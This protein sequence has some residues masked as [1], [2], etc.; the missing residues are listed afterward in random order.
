MRQKCICGLVGLILLAI[1]LHSRCGLALADESTACT[2][3]L[4]QTPTRDSPPLCKG[5]LGGYQPHDSTFARWPGDGDSALV[6]QPDASLIPPLPPLAKGGRRTVAEP[7]DASLIPPLPS[8]AKGG[9]RTVAEPADAS[10][11]PPLTPFAKGGRRT[12]VEPP[13]TS[14][15]LSLAPLRRGE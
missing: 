15:I 13:D 12:V 5:G 8:L 11:T 4:S 9:R 6:E 3:T 7:A 1:G 2:P 10:L 14:L